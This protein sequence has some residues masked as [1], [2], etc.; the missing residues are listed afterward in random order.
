MDT[1]EFELYLN[2]L[3]I[4][5]EVKFG[6]GDS[7][8]ICSGGSCD[9]GELN[10]PVD[11]VFTTLKESGEAK[12]GWNHIAIKLSDMS[13]TDGSYGPFN[14]ANV[15][16][17]RIFWVA[18]SMPSDSVE[19]F[20]IKFDNFRLTA[21]GKIAADKLAQ[22][23]AEFDSK[24]ADLVAAIK[25]LDA[26][27]SSSKITA[28]NYEA[29]KA[30]I[31]GVRAQ[32]NALSENDQRIASEAGYTNYLEKAE[33]SLK[34]YEEDLQKVKDA[35]AENQELVDKING[36]TTS[37]TNDNYEAQKKAAEEARA[38]YDK[39]TRTV[40]GYFEDEGLTEKLEAAEAAIAAFDPTKP[41]VTTECEHADADADGKCDKCG[42]D[43]G[44]TP[45]TIGDDDDTTDDDGGC[46]SALTIGAVAMMVLAGAWVTIAARKKD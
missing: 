21:A 14:L 23:K 1:L 9:Q 8:E 39:L 22:E 43:M 29:A 38:A 44:T 6:G 18:A 34:K 32:V 17:M 11:K 27:K 40:K 28:E 36:L 20:T 41:P 10:Y 31:Q 45:P 24:Y 30:E 13:A 2:D 12:V 26:Y 4:L 19:R 42:K 25:A 46:K 15:D 16:F 35:L 33:K 3:A 7:I 37:I 5:D